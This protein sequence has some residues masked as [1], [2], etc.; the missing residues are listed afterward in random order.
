VFCTKTIQQPERFQRDREVE[1]LL[2]GA[3]GKAQSMM[4]DRAFLFSRIS[5]ECAPTSQGLKPATLLCFPSCGRNLLALWE[6]YKDQAK[7]ELGL[8]HYELGS[9]AKHRSVLFFQR[10]ILA[11]MLQTENNIAFLRESDYDGELTIEAVLHRLQQKMQQ[12]YP[13]EIGLLLGIPLADIRGF[14]ANQG[15]GCLL[16]GYWKVYHDPQ[17][18]GCQCRY[19][20]A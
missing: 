15:A 7:Q 3:F 10:E 16:C 12:D 2:L 5:F 8:D 9:S 18:A 19:D 1:T 14:I 20:F 6:T 4:D 11:T 13:H 17:Q